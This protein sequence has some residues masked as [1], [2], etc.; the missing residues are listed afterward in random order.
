[1]C[2][3]PFRESFERGFVLW[4]DRKST[5]LNSS[6]VRISY[7]VFCLKKQTYQRVYQIV[8]PFVSKRDWQS[9]QPAHLSRSL[10]PAAWEE[11]RDIRLD[12]PDF[13]SHLRPAF[14]YA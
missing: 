12:S 10:P 9:L 6:H 2:S 3:A 11:G 5:R 8:E 7:A 14:P 1:M 4:E 13:A